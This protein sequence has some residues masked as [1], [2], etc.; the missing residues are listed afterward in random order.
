MKQ[1]DVDVGACRR[2]KKDLSVVGNYQVTSR[3][4]VQPTVATVAG[5]IHCA[6]QHFSFIHRQMTLLQLGYQ[7]FRNHYG[8]SRQEPF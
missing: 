8:S 4:R 1:N 6:F 5:S 3:Y 2:G 7:L